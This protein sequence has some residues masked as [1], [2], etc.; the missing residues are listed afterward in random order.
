[1][2]FYTHNNPHQLNLSL[3]V[4]QEQKTLQSF[5]IQSSTDV[6]SLEEIASELCKEEGELSCEVFV[7]L[8]NAMDVEVDVVITLLVKNSVIELKEGIWQSFMANAIASTL[9][10]YF[11]PKSF[12]HSISIL[13][14]SK[15]V[16]MSLNYTLWESDRNS[17]NPRLWPFPTC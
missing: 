4:M 6:L 17:I 2:N 10:F 8:S 1:M 11:M 13:H 5:Q 7:T 3:A 14:Q 16:D 9:H 12:N 15:L